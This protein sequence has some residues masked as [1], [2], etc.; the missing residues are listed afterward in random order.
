MAEKAHIDV[1]NNDAMDDEAMRW[2]M[3]RCDALCGD[4]MRRYDAR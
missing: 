1:S 2:T 3:Q 4:A